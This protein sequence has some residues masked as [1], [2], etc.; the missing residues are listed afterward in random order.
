MAGKKKVNKITTV[1]PLPPRITFDHVGKG[2]GILKEAPFLIN[3][4]IRLNYV[5]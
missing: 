5:P 1:L 4:D 3:I 2:F